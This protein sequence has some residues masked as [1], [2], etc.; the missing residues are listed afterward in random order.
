VRDVT[1]TPHD[2]AGDRLNI[3]G[4]SQELRAQAQWLRSRVS[5]AGSVTELLTARFTANVAIMGLLA[6]SQF[7]AV[8]PTSGGML[9][10]PAEVRVSE[11]FVILTEDHDLGVMQA[12][13][14]LAI[15]L[16]VAGYD[17]DTEAVSGA[18]AIDIV[19]AFA[20]RT[21]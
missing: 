6:R 11:L 19:A 16:H 7:D 21:P 13:R 3:R 15:A 5:A 4:Q 18:D 9:A 17:P 8:L 14:L 2:T 10:A 20:R 12:V 1:L